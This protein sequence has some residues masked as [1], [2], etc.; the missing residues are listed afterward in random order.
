MKIYLRRSHNEG[1]V[2]PRFYLPV[3]M[4]YDSFSIECWIFFL[5]PFVLLYK[6]TKDVFWLIWKDLLDFYKNL[7]LKKYK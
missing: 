7:S 4:N 5:A 6:I 3:Y 2:I 1:E